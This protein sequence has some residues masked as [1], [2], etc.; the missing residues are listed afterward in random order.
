MLAW[1]N[2]RCV[3]LWLCVR[4][5]PSFACHLDTGAPT[6]M[7]VYAEYACVCAVHLRRCIH[8][9]GLCARLRACVRDGGG[10]GGGTWDGLQWLKSLTTH[11]F[12][13]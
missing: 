8:R 2:C 3:F 10:N 12:H 1:R 6:S 5:Q 4:K 7:A 9:S 13:R 11:H